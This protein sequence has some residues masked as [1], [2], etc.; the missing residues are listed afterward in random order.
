MVHLV[1][2]LVHGWRGKEGAA[3]ASA[4]PREVVGADMGRTHGFDE[5][6]D[7]Y[8]VT[9]TRG[10]DVKPPRIAGRKRSPAS[11]WHLYHL[12]SNSRHLLTSTWLR[13]NS[14]IVSLAE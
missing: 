11:N 12:T 2:I 8:S 14:G 6:V 4:A 3:G 5:N 7:A 1:N 13:R 9:P 10:T